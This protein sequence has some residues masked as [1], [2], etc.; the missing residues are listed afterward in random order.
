MIIYMQK[1][2]KKILVLSSNIADQRNG[3]TQPNVVV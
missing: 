3:H 1:K 2:K